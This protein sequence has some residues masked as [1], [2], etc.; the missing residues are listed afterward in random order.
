MEKVEQD[1]SLQT[2]S[3]S[4]PLAPKRPRTDCTWKS[5][6]S[7]IFD[8]PS[9]I[10]PGNE[11]L[12]FPEQNG[13]A[14]V[15]K[16]CEQAQ[17]TEINV[18]PAAEVT[19]T[20]TASPNENHFLHS[21]QYD[22]QVQLLSGSET[23]KDCTGEMSSRIE[24]QRHE[25]SLE[26]KPPGD[27]SA[28]SKNGISIHKEVECQ[29]DFSRDDSVA[30][31][32]IQRESNHMD[33]KHNFADNIVQMEEK[34][35]EKRDKSQ[36]FDLTRDEDIP[37]ILLEDK[38]KV[39]I[40]GG[41]AVC[42]RETNNDNGRSALS[43]SVECTEGSLI[44]YDSAAAKNIAIQ[45]GSTDDIGWAKG[46]LGELTAEAQG[47]IVDHTPENHISVRFCRECAEGDNDAHPLSVIDPAVSGETVREAEGNH[48]NSGSSASEVLPPSVKVCE[49]EI[50]LALISGGRPLDTAVQLSNQ[51]V[52]LQHNDEKENWS[53]LYTQT[54][55]YCVG[56]S[57]TDNTTS[58]DG[59]C[60]SALSPQRPETP[61]PA[62]DEIEGSRGSMGHHAHEQ[63]SCLPVSCDNPKAQHVEHPWSGTGTTD[64]PVYI[65]EMAGLAN[66]CGLYEY[67]MNSEKV[68]LQHN[69]P[70][71]D[72]M[73]EQP[74]VE[75]L[76]E[77]T[78][79]IDENSHSFFTEYH[80]T[81]ETLEEKDELLPACFPSIKDAVVPGP[82]ELS[83]KFCSQ[84]EDIDAVLKNK[85]TFSPVPSAFCLYNAMSGGFDNFHKLQLSPDDDEYDDDV[86]QD[87]TSMARKLIKSPQMNPSV[88]E[89]EGDEK[90]EMPKETEMDQ[91]HEKG[92]IF[93]CHTD[94][95]ARGSFDSATNCTELVSEQELISSECHPNEPATDSSGSNEPR[96]IQYPEF[97][98]KKEYDLVLKELNLY[99]LISRSDSVCVDEAPKLEECSDVMWCQASQG[100]G[101]ISSTEPALHCNQSS[102]PDEDRTVQI[103]V[104][105]PESCHI[106]SHGG[107]QEV[108]NG[109]HLLQEASDPWQTELKR[110]AGSFMCLPL[111]QPQHH[112]LP[113]QAKKLE[114]LR[115]CT[116]PIR[117][118][119]S[120]RA[121][122]KPCTVSTLT[123]VPNEV[124]GTVCESQCIVYW[125]VVSVV[126]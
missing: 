97:D 46:E 71:N 121:K 88:L 42:D 2:D 92:G 3:E 8:S 91:I 65:Q 36:L 119:L 45:T 117:L 109:H 32:S 40:Y 10:A 107:E 74:L 125:T 9:L 118:G 44:S 1:A 27:C 84:S 98:M 103:S 18:S 23:F 105:D 6:T 63:S 124:V 34:E 110:T 61:F 14:R 87:H 73:T 108:P 81:D 33:D 72:A 58:C 35:N 68:M 25:K 41:P 95:S 47:K 104:T 43:S 123:N 100:K 52:P 113:W 102:D 70:D 66:E 83:P 7:Q 29:S 11:S 13:H 51:S 122:P 21:K 5:L 77:A 48:F 57:E 75:G 49:L 67:E 4:L 30:S 50:P 26:D 99:F 38:S 20:H 111:L 69:R 101:H 115:T 28:P 60:P 93:E 37:V 80:Q 85:D 94:D 79:R 22:S 116:R 16:S 90:E 106:C 24:W 62:G 55:S 19:T 89:S 64:E 54:Q 96:S 59:S 53:Q 120:K 82:H 15:G 126:W 114:P 112:T 86:G 78:R 31:L 12:V 39:K 76:T 17:D 56:S